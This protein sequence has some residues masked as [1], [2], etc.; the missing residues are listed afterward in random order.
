MDVL[1]PA[2]SCSSG[3]PA[4]TS[5]WCTSL[6]EGVKTPRSS[7]KP[8]GILKVGAE[9]WVGEKLFILLL[10]FATHCVDAEES[11]LIN[12]QVSNLCSQW[13]HFKVKGR[14]T[15]A[16]DFHSMKPEVSKALLMPIWEGSSIS[17]VWNDTKAS[18]HQWASDVGISEGSLIRH[19]FLMQIYHSFS[20]RFRW[21]RKLYSHLFLWKLGQ[22]QTRVDPRVHIS[23]CEN[24]WEWGWG[25]R[26]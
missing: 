18:G 2:C 3:Y 9:K 7:K 26:V 22:N 6:P 13:I 8:T 14:A 10:F 16:L 17:V 5:H 24:I 21:L 12:C 23:G 1:T 25:E 11:T 19:L 20:A 4:Y 15:T